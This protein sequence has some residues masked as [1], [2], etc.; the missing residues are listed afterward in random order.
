MFAWGAFSHMAL[1][2]GDLG[3]QPLSEEAAVTA[4]LKDK[5]KNPGLYYYPY[6]DDAAAMERLLKERPR[7]ILT[8]TPVETPFSMGASLGVQCLND[9]LEGIVLAWLLGWVAPAL[10]GLGARMAFAA[11]MAVL[12][13]VAFLGPYWN[14]Y[15]F[16]PAFVL[17]GL[18]DVG[19]GAVLGAAV[20]SKIALRPA[21]EY[22]GV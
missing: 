3:I 14:W 6:S 12:A 15:G 17:G 16:P 20:I 8:Y 10:P 1:H 11:G 13:T 21:R 7:G 9:I 18:L 2:L 5:V 22:V 19:L 4:V